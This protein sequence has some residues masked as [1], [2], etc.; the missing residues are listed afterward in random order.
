MVRPQC[1][2]RYAIA[3]QYGLDLL[4]LDDLHMDVDR[5][6]DLPGPGVQEEEDMMACFP[7]ARAVG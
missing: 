7:T 6:C 1:F 4:Q 5:Q 3:I 2:Y